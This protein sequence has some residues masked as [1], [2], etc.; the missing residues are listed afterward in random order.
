MELDRAQD[1]CQQFFPEI[2][3]I[4]T[5]EL[6]SGLINKTYVVETIDKK[7]VLQSINIAVFNQFL[8]GLDNI[9]VVKKWLVKNQFPYEFPTPIEN[10]YLK[11]HNKIWRLFNYVLD[12]KVMDA[13]KEGQ[14]AYQAAKC[15]GIFYKCLNSFPVDKLHLTLPDFHNGEMRLDELISSY[16]N[17]SKNRKSNGF[18]LFSRIISQK[19]LV[20]KF[21]KLCEKLPKRVVHYDTKISNF[22]F[23]KNTNNVKAIIDLDTIMPGCVLS[24]IGDMIRTFSNVNGEESK[25]LDKVKADKNTI[26]QIIQAFTSEAILTVQEKKYLYFSGIAITLIQ[27][28]RFLTDYFNDDFYYKTTYEEH[29]IVRSK[30][31]WAL[32]NSLR[33]MQS[34]Y[35]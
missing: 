22:L 27:C 30:N 19:H 9:I 31:Q 16:N 3:I 10:R 34:I 21:Q 12:T 32:F 33:E 15:L 28:I 8:K 25:R 18:E 20:L 4:G 6:K 14:Q 24:D 5:F 35:N 7:Y 17:S 23:Q 29:N 1:I 2:K 11:R 13:V 26:D